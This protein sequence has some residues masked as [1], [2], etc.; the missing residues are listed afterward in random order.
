MFCHLKMLGY[1][2]FLSLSI[3]IYIQGGCISFGLYMSVYNS[4]R[5][6]TGH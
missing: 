5:D 3:Y 4:E 6:V 2:I 1:V